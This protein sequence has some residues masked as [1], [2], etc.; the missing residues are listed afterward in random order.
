MESEESRRCTDA[1]WV[2]PESLKLM[3]RKTETL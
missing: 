1:G 3:K 2:I